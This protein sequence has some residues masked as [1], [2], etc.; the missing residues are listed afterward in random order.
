MNVHSSLDYCAVD[1]YTIADAYLRTVSSLIPGNP[2]L[3]SGGKARRSILPENSK[4]ASGAWQ[5]CWTSRAQAVWGPSLLLPSG[6]SPTLQPT[7]A[8]CGVIQM[9]EGVPGQSLLESHIGPGS[10]RDSRRD[11]QLSGYLLLASV[12]I[13]FKPLIESFTTGV[14]LTS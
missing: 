2:S 8:L 3:C 5:Q 11:A 9:P 14:E 1:C 4:S 7:R 13:S 10:C 6:R 12:G